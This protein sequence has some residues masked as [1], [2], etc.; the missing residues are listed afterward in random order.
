MRDEMSLAGK[1]V[2]WDR[3]LGAGKRGRDPGGPGAGLRNLAGL[4][5]PRRRV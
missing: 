2:T 3:Y 5:P 4:C 1:V